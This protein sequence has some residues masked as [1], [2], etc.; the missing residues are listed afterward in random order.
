MNVG[1]FNTQVGTAWDILKGLDLGEDR[2]FHPSYP[3]NPAAIFR[4]LSYED[5]WKLCFQEQYYDIQLIDD[6]LIQ[7][8]VE[9]FTPLLM[10]YVYYE[11]PYT[12]TMPFDAFLRDYLELDDWED[13]HHVRRDY[14]DYYALSTPKEVVTP[15]RYDYSPNL[16]MEGRHPASHLRFGHNNSIRVGTKKILRP[17]SFICFILR[18]VYPDHWTQFVS[19]AQA[20]IWARNVRD[21]LD[22]VG[23]EYWN[24]L[25]HWEMSLL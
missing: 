9:S 13:R 6:S 1:Q 24:D 4:P 10:S 23:E 19:L 21:N 8:R 12:P 20:N 16:Y 3:D 18:H 15:I 25:D 2:V 11:C 22:N 14:E 7:F 17:I 5:I